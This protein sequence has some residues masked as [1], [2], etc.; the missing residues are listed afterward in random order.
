[1]LGVRLPSC[2]NLN[3]N[4]GMAGKVVEKSLRREGDFLKLHFLMLKLEISKFVDFS[5]FVWGGGQAILAC[6]IQLAP[7]F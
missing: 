7:D 5:L 2:E 6:N 3:V 4:S 1:M